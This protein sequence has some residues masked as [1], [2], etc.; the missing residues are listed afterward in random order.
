MEE[1]GD[2]SSV[3]GGEARQHMEHMEH[4]NIFQVKIFVIEKV[5]LFKYSGSVDILTKKDFFLFHL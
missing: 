2:P 1:S 3:V 5:P 4:D